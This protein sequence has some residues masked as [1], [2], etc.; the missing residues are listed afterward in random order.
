MWWCTIFTVWA[1]VWFVN[2]ILLQCVG[3]HEQVC[4]QAQYPVNACVHFVEMK[5][6]NY[7]CKVKSTMSLVYWM[8][9][10]HIFTKETKT[11]M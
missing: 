10:K 2:Q 9:K 11:N 4:K 6:Y 7:V 5:A 3:A 1:I 8:N